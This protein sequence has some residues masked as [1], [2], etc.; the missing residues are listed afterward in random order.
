M[1]I[2]Y[3]QFCCSPFHKSDNFS[4]YEGAFINC[5]IKAENKDLALVIAKNNISDLQWV[6]DKLEEQEVVG[7]EYYRD[8]SDGLERYNQALL[9]GS[10]F[11]IHTWERKPN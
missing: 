7:A 3:F 1:E 9:N 2:Y 8:N 5:W 4:E 6:I 10:C 11:V